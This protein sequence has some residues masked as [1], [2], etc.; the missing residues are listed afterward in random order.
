VIKA[1]QF[2]YFIAFF[3][4]LITKASLVLAQ[5]PGIHFEA[6]A[7]DRN[8]N[9]AKDRRIYIKATILQGAATG[10][11]VLLRSIGQGQIARVYF[12]LLLE[13]VRVLEELMLLS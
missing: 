6:I 13:M 4:L 2:I 5:Q 1:N 8:N 11:P 12:K 10:S 3:L 9:P 7:R